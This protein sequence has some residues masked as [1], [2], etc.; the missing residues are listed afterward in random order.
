MPNSSSPVT[1]ATSEPALLS[2]RSRMTDAASALLPSRNS[3]MSPRN[4]A[5]AL[6]SVGSLLSC[7]GYMYALRDR[8]S[9]STSS[10][11]SPYFSGRSR[12]P[13]KNMTS[14]WNE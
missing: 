7:T 4:L 5:Y 3:S 1:D 6:I 8:M 14:I 12:L 13:L 2:S 11:L 10:I 9:I